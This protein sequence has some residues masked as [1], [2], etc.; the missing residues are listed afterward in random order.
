[1]RIL[2]Y[3]AGVIGSFNAARLSAAG[4]DVSLLARGARPAELREH[5]VVLEDTRSGL[6]TAMRVPLVERL[7]P[8]DAYDLV[9]VAMRRNQV[10]AILPDLARSART[11][12]VLFLGNNAAGPAPWVAALGPER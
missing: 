1:M 7:D 6:P 10:P 2:V 3:G 11:P 4:H 12:S 8:D 9:V 5:G